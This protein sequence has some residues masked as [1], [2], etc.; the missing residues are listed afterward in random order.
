LVR[1]CSADG[2]VLVG[3]AVAE[4]FPED[5]DRFLEANIESVDQL[6]ILRVLGEEPGREWPIHEL[7]GAL[8]VGEQ[9][10][11][12]N[13][14]A[15]QGRGLLTAERRDPV[16]V[17]RSGANSPDLERLVQRLLQLYRERPVSMIRIVYA[18]AADPLRKFSD[19]FRLR[20]E[21]G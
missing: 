13:V 11:A 14:W 12:R 2:A 6:E 4:P 10:T 18:R 16:A 21:G 19:A 5:L 17:C 9:D 7:A 3:V 20:G 15:L 8:H 1:E